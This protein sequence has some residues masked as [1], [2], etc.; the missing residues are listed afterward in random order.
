MLQSHTYAET[1][2]EMQKFMF[3]FEQQAMQWNIF[4][5]TKMS[6]AAENRNKLFSNLIKNNN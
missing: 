2:F 1:S 5:L 4:R 6:R 3:L